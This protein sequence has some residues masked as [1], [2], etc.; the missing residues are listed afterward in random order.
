MSIK[1][2]NILLFGQP[3]TQ[4]L[5]EMYG[6]ARRWDMAFASGMAAE[7]AIL[8]LSVQ[9]ITSSPDDDLYGGTYRIFERVLRATLKQLCTGWW[10]QRL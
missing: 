5:R 8:S 4:S 1:A 6:C 10:C 2:L 3:N 9:V 7:S